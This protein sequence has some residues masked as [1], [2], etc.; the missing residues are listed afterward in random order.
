MSAGG[1]RSMNPYVEF[2]PV[3]ILLQA[4]AHW[5]WRFMPAPCAGHTQV[6]TRG[7]GP[8]H[9]SVLVSEVVVQQRSNKTSRTSR[10]RGVPSI[11]KSWSR[12]PRPP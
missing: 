11:R 6:L 5:T 8:T 4:A 7:P 9:Q 12:S 2:Y 3:F 1:R 10:M